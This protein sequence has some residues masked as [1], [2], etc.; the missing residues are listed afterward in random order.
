MKWIYWLGWLF[1]RSVARSFFGYRVHGR[2]NLVLD[3]PVLIASNHESY[4]DPPLLGVIYDTEVHY[5]ARKTLFTGFQAWLYRQWNSVPVDQERPDMTSLKTIIKLL[6]QGEKVV[7]FP[8][9]QR[10]WDGTLGAAQP[11]IGLIVAKT[12]VVIQP[13]R[14]RGAREALPRGSGRLRCV[15]VS[16]TVGKPLQFPREQLAAAKGKDG[17]QKIADR[18]MAEIAAI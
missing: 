5:L 16:V 1:F 4:V 15:R 18:I 11:G 17:Y 14:I 12:G 6:Q 9:G 2:E 13:I 3:G 7:V 10:T 8:E